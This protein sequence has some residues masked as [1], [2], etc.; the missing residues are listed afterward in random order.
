MDW[1]SKPFLFFVSLSVKAWVYIVIIG[2]LV[3]FVILPLLRY[4]VSKI[5]TTFEPI[6]FNMQ[7][8]MIVG[9]SDGL[10]KAIVKEVFLKGALVTMI[11]RDEAKLRSIRDELDT[12]Q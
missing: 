3:W 9:A 2:L 8:V 6:R 1:I 4:C 7:H 11:G 5:K 10:G 12:S